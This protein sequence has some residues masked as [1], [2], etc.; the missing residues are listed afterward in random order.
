MPNAILTDATAPKRTITILMAD[1]D[2]D[3]HLLARKALAE[4]KADANLSRIPMMIL[5][6]SKAETDILHSHDLGAIS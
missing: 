2:L 3:D 1:D 4:I 5:K 6:T